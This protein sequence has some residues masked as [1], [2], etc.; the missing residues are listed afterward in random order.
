MS[1][2]SR[3]T[4]EFDM[5]GMKRK[6][7]DDEGFSEEYQT[8]KF[9]ITLAKESPRECVRSDDDATYD[10]FHGRETDVCRDTSDTETSGDETIAVLEYEVATDSSS[11][12]NLYSDDSSSGSEHDV[13]IA[14]LTSLI[15]D[16]ISG[17]D[18]AIFA[19][20]EASDDS[21]TD[22]EINRADYWECVKCKNKQNNPLY[23]YCE[24]CYRTRKDYFPPRPKRRRKRTKRRTKDRRRS[25]RGARSSSASDDEADMGEIKDRRRETEPDGKGSVKGRRCLVSRQECVANSAGETPESD[26]EEEAAKDGGGVTRSG[27]AGVN[28]SLGDRKRRSSRSSVDIL[29]DEEDDVCKRARY[30]NKFFKN[31]WDNEPEESGVQSCASSQDLSSLSPTTILPESQETAICE[32]L[33]LARAKELSGSSNPL[34]EPCMMCLKEPKDGVFVHSSFLHLCCCY[35]C[36][37]KAWNK[38]KRCPICNSKVKNVLRLFVH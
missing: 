15:D 3:E 22:P 31:V 19:D 35:K 23:R 20:T 24:K 30:E 17:S 8:P 36:A 32:D 27:G 6:H 11:E 13:V 28:S 2:V 12:N 29:E 21:A 9:Y 34:D 16:S 26:E 4:Q 10:S 14:A 25:L 1:V 38:H 18:F 7:R 33:D 37:K 5:S